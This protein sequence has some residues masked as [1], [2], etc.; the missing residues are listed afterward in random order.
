MNG[1]NIAQK[2]KQFD[3]KE[4]KMNWVTAPGLLEDAREEARTYANSG[5]S[6][7]APLV[8]SEARQSLELTAR[9]VVDRAR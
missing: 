1:P 4:E 9:Y 3:D 2:N 5:L 6:E 8:T 7:L